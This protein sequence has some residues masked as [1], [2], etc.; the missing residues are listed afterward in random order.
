MPGW[1]W[2]R[3]PRSWW[4]ERPA[5]LSDHF[6][7]SFKPDGVAW[8]W[9]TLEEAYKRVKDNNHN[10]GNGGMRFQLYDM[11]E[12]LLGGHHDIE[13]PIV[14][15][16]Y[17]LE[18]WR[19]DLLFTDNRQSTSLLAPSR[20]V[21]RDWSEESALLEFLRES[22]AASQRRHD[23]MLNQMRASQQSFEDIM[24]SYLKKN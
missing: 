11:M 13:F 2:A 17:V 16:A 12:E 9:G 10:T 4:K 15:T 22:E 23:E 3:V 21:R 1:R 8:K 19:P 6:K 20:T 18:I 5:K 14:G 24:K 7:L